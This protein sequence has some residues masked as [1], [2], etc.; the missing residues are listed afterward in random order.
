MITDYK[1]ALNKLIE[2][3]H[4]TLLRKD[5][6][7]VS[8]ALWDIQSPINDPD[9]IGYIMLMQENGHVADVYKNEFEA[10]V[11]VW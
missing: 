2:F 8:G 4:G 9:G 7:R 11:D 3:R 5:G 6:V 1:E 10:L